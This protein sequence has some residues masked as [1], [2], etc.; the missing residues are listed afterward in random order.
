M[1]RGIRR[2]DRNGSLVIV[3]T[4]V[5]S[6]WIGWTL[7]Q[8]RGGISAPFVMVGV[9]MM[10]MM[11]IVVVSGLDGHEREAEPGDEAVP[12]GG[13]GE[14]PTQPIRNRYWP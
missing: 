5:V 6:G 1:I 14:R 13:V 8:G 9:M 2:W 10:M 12:S 3:T 7:F 4:Y 11:V